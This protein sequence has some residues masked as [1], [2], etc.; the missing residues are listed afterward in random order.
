MKQG[1]GEPKTENHSELQRAADRSSPGKHHSVGVYLAI[2]FAVAFI[3]LL[4][5]YFMQQR[6]N[7][8]VISGLRDSASAVENLQQ[9]QDSNKKLSTQVGQ[10]QDES[11]KL[12]SQLTGAQS[13]LQESQNELS[14]M[15]LLW[16]IS[17]LYASRR[18][19]ACRKA[20]AKMEE[21][22]LSQYLPDKSVNSFQQESPLSEYQRIADALN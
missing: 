8:E 20:I 3:L 15:D 11:D 5:S 22:N 7:A 19:T 16:Q 17:K 2:L 18:Y 9:L 21:L 13:S 1:S 14:A 10:L 6:N 4:L 12:Q